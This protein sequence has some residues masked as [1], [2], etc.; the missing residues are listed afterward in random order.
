VGPIFTQGK[1]VVLNLPQRERAISLTSLP[2]Y[3]DAIKLGDR[4]LRLDTKRLG[5]K[6]Q[7]E[8]EKLLT[9]W[10]SSS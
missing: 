4:Q 3:Q 10:A 9:Q 6:W 5:N 7:E 2:E 8:L 1:L